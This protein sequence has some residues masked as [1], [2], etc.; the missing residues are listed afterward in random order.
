MT[1]RLGLCG[2]SFNPFH[3]GHLQPLAIYDEMH[4]SQLVYVPAN[5]QPF[6]LDRL[7][8]SAFHRFAMTVLATESDERLGVSTVE[9]DREG[10]SYTVDTLEEM[11][12]LYPDAVLDWIIGD[13]NI[14]ALGAW[15]S[16][17]RIFE[18]ANFV[19]L[20][21]TN[22]SRLPGQYAFRVTSAE[23]RDKAGGIIFA[24]NPAVEVSSSDVRQRVAR[25][26]SVEHLVD[27][28][29]ARYIRR[30]RLYQAEVS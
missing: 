2:G 16:I 3:R 25:G 20:R 23:G 7:Q 29:V 10:V 5:R 1:E 19:V 4:W 12:G 27:D 21:R 11:R 13:D 6:K 18:L 8:P 30:N 14:D 17:E 24:H 28:R 15:R 22:L 26:E 9:V